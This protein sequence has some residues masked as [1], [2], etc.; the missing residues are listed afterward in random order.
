MQK[1]AYRLLTAQ[2][3]ATAKA[4]RVMNEVTK[5]ATNCRGNRLF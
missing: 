3:I 2:I 5:A 1:D 4:K